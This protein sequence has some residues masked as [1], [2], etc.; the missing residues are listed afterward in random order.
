MQFN[1]P[2]GTDI[3]VSNTPTSSLN[4]PVGEEITIS[5]GATGAKTAGGISLDVVP[6]SNF[7]DL[8]GAIMPDSGNF[9]DFA[10]S[11]ALSMM[12][13]PEGTFSKYAEG[14]DTILNNMA[15]ENQRIENVLQEKFGDNYSGKDAIGGLTTNDRDS[16]ARRSQF[17]DKFAF[18]KRKYPEGRLI[19]TGVGGKKNRDA[20]LTY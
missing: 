8:L 3:N 10:T 17:A 15:L 14:I 12:T 11:P 18:F 6:D 2:T 4:E 20:I 5:E 7:F 13:K 9:L 19:R 1:E 16:L